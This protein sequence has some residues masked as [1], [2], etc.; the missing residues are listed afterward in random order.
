VIARNSPAVEL[1]NHDGLADAERA[2]ARKEGDARRCRR[3]L[4]LSKFDN[5][6]EIIIGT[7][8]RLRAICNTVALRYISNSIW[9]PSKM[10][11][12]IRRRG[13]RARRDWPRRLLGGTHGSGA[14]YCGGGGFV[15]AIA[16][17]TIG[18][19]TNSRAFTS[20]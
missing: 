16:A 12:T 5:D 7:A 3:R 11:S 13:D 20:W 8:Y 14:A 19:S 17:A 18:P 10:K 15:H 4:E 2:G 1:C 6:H 9:P